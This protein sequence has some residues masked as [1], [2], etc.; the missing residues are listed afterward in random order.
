M[1]ADNP[2]STAGKSIEW[3]SRK[4]N[5]CQVDGHWTTKVTGWFIVEC[6]C[7]TIVRA[8]VFGFLTGTCF[9]L[10]AL[11]AISKL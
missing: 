9:A 3:V 8:L 11:Y 6:G 1:E 2:Q 5:I 4:L 10:A 7:C